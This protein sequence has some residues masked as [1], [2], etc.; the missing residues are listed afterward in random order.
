[1]AVDADL[2]VAALAEGAGVLPLDADGALALLG[3]AGVIEDQDG[4]A[5]GGQG[6]HPPDPLAV[7]VVLVPG[8]LGEQALE[9]LLGGAGDDLGD[10]VAI[11]VG[12]LGQQ[13][14]EVAFEGG[15]ALAAG[16]V[17][18]ERLQEPASSGSGVRAERGAFGSY[19]C[20]FYGSGMAWSSVDKVVLTANPADRSAKGC[21][22]NT[23]NR[24]DGPSPCRREVRRSRSHRIC[25]S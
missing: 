21:L 17:D 18:A 1:M 22:D 2:A 4:I 5:L 15:G 11:L 19:S 6:E 20:P 23:R 14:G 16:E 13:P 10:G 24:R 8:H 7:E 12:L 9:A 3:E 25:S